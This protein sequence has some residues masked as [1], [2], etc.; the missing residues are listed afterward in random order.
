[1]GKTYKQ[2]HDDLYFDDLTD[3][4]PDDD[5][6]DEEPDSLLF[7]EPTRRSPHKRDRRARVDSFDNTSLR[8]LSSQ[9]RL[10]SDWMDF[11]YATGPSHEDWR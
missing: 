3:F 5:F 10:P 4:D 11:D 7:D 2:Q 6:L 1:M 8:K 9:H